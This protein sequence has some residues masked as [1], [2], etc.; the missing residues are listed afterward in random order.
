MD[1]TAL[2]GQTDRGEFQSG[3]SAVDAADGH[4]RQIIVTHS[5]QLLD[6]FTGDFSLFAVE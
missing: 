2:C 4:T 3:R 5:Q 6:P 1:K